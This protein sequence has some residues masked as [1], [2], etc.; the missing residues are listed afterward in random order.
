MSTPPPEHPTGQPG[1]DP[2]EATTR[3]LTPP[4][5]GGQSGGGQYGGGQYGGGQYGPPPGQPAGPQY[6]PPPAGYPSVGAPPAGFG[7]GPYPPPAP[8]PRRRTGLIVGI[9]VGVVVLLGGLGLVAVLLFGT[10]SVSKSELEGHLT[11]LRSVLAEPPQSASCP[12][13][14]E[15]ETGKSIDCTVRLSD[16]TEVPGRITVAATDGGADD[17][18]IQAAVAPKAQLGELLTADVKRQYEDIAMTCEGD[19]AGQQ[20]ASVD[21]D[22][23]GTDGLPLHVKATFAM[24]NPDLTVVPAFTPYLTAREL[25]QLVANYYS[26]SLGLSVTVTCPDDVLGKVGESTT[27]KVTD[28]VGGAEQATASVT[29]I[30]RGYFIQFQLS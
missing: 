29:S 25:S 27:C 18:R 16:G 26:T 19:L 12:G 2:A 5:G 24:L 21:C 23:T 8:A 15:F 22:G 6:P 13:D 7:G 4:P 14:L 1:N 30:D 3:R 20:G 17:L 10:R 9:V 28:N 11:G